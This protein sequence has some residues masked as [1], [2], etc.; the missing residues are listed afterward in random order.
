MVIHVEM[1]I[2]NKYPYVEPTE[3]IPEGKD[4]N[5]GI[6]LRLINSVLNSVL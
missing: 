1:T 2:I 3:E 6:N 5:L 4:R